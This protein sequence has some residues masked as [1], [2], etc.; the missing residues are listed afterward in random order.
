MARIAGGIKRY[1]ATAVID[2]LA[3]AATYVLAIAVRTGGRPEIFDP[4]I[5]PFA[6]VSALGAGLLQV[7]CN[8]LFDV[9][10]RD[11]SAAA[12]EDMV[13]L[14]KATTV[15]VVALLALVVVALMATLRRAHRLHVRG[16]ATGIPPVPEL[17]GEVDAELSD[18]SRDAE[19]EG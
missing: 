1:G 18:P 14:V 2:C 19:R 6:L 13:A 17:E 15:V 9:Y 5:A 7:L 4:V 3:V 10:W 16:S 12:I 8:L 11:W